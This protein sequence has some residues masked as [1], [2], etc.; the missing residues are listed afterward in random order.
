MCTFLQ[1]YFQVA[2]LFQ[3]VWV[4]F[5][6]ISKLCWNVLQIFVT[7][8]L[9]NYRFDAYFHLNFIVPFS[10][11]LLSGASLSF[12]CWRYLL[13]KCKKLTKKVKNN[14]ET[15]TTYGKEQQIKI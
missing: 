4:Y 8:H 10:C 12:K 11:G 2:K 6:E 7:F 13:Y 15:Y 14:E 5:Y 3:F 9:L 1:A